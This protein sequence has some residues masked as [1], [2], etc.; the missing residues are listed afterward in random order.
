MNQE[1][2]LYPVPHMIKIDTNTLATSKFERRNHVAVSC[3]NDD[4]VHSIPEG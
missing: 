1:V 4:G 2:P 3:H